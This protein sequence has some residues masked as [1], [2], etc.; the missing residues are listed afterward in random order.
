V[1]I[2]LYLT[3]RPYS[4]FLP[5]GVYDVLFFLLLLVPLYSLWTVI[6][7]N[8]DKLSELFILKEKGTKCSCG[9]ENSGSNRYCGKCGLALSEKQNP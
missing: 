4:G 8:T 2:T 9:W 5:Y 6:D 1:I 7:K 3:F